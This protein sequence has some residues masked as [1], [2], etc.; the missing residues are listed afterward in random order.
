MTF[1]LELFTTCKKVVNLMVR[2]KNELNFHM[3][4]ISNQCYISRESRLYS[5]MIVNIPIVVY[6]DK[7]FKTKLIEIQMSFLHK[8]FTIAYSQRNLIDFYS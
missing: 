2:D 1:C 8:N 7:S 3:I 6:L 5:K 4:R